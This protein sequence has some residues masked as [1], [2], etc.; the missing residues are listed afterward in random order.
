MAYYLDTLEKFRKH[1]R[2]VEPTMTHSRIGTS[3]KSLLVAKI[4]DLADQLQKKKIKISE[5]I[6][7][8]SGI[9]NY[10]TDFKIAAELEVNFETRNSFIHHCVVLNRLA[11]INFLLKKNSQINL[12]IMNNKGET[13]L[14]IAAKSGAISMIKLLVYLGASLKPIN[15]A[16]KT[17]LDLLKANDL[18]FLATKNSYPERKFITPTPTKL[19]A[20]PMTTMKINI[21]DT[22]EEVIDDIFSNIRSYFRDRGHLTPKE[23]TESCEID[24][25]AVLNSGSVEASLATN[26]D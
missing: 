3:T 4:K 23:H 18:E 25:S 5:A 10:K 13:P 6:S 17:P 12:N 21:E 1:R 19:K 8:I 9:C 2:T 20:S 11:L 7:I 26:E 15:F 22:K 24:A 14:H 16:G